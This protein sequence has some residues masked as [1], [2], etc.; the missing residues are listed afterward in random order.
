MERQ[1]TYGGVAGA[2]LAFSLLLMVLA[3]GFV[4]GRVMVARMYVGA[5]PDIQR[6]SVREPEAM[7]QIAEERALLPG[8]VY[9][10]PPAPPE[11]PA[12]EMVEREGP[13]AEVEGDA[14]GQVRVMEGAAA[15]PAEA[16]GV[17]GPAPAVPIAPPPPRPARPTPGSVGEESSQARYSIQMGVFAAREGAREVADELARA[18]YPARIEVTSTEEQALYRVLT[19]R[20]RTEYAARKAMDE[21]RREGFPGFL[22]EH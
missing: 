18:G 6:Q 2:F 14:G 5:A 17:E 15:A 4:V 12:E 3:I 22:V 20:Y 1:G 11:E 21:L 9:V 19:G 16:V 7:A 8:S 10:P 13:E